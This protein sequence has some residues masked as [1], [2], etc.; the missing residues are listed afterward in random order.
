[1][2]A[3]EIIKNLVNLVGVTAG[4]IITA[5]GSI[6]LINSVL[7]VYVF[8]IEVNS[9]FDPKWTCEKYDW[10]TREFKKLENNMLSSD[11]NVNININN[12]K[13]ELT[14]EQKEELDKKHKECLLDE[15][16]KAK[17]KYFANKKEE[18]GDGLAFLIVGLP[19]LFF[20]QRRK[21]KNS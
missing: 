12:D 9:H 2:K 4:I 6:M 19:I 16:I 15:E 14:Q 1:M 13:K 21:N 20:Y 8:G 5:V 17:N 10:E 11:V 3:T 7:K 18:M